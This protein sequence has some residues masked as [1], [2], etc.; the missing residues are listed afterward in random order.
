MPELGRHN[1]R[2]IATLSGVAPSKGDSGKLCGRRT[3]TGGREVVRS[4]LYMSVLISIRRKYPLGE[5]YHSLRATGKPAK[6]ATVACMRKLVT[7]GSDILS[8][9]KP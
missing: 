1:R 8:G 9:E 5:S 6:V 4:A 2:Q 3:I 7:T